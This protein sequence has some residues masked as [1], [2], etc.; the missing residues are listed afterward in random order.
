MEGLIDIS[1]YPAVH[2]VFRFLSVPFTLI[3]ILGLYVI[4][5]CT[6]RRVGSYKNYMLFLQ[7]NAILYDLIFSFLIFPI[8]SFPAGGGYSLGCLSELGISVS[9]QMPL[10]FATVAAFLSALGIAL[11]SRQQTILHHGHRFKYSEEK[12]LRICVLITLHP[13]YLVVPAVLLV[14]YFVDTTKG[15][16]YHYSKYPLLEEFFVQPTYYAVNVEMKYAC[17][18]SINLMLFLTIL[19]FVYLITPTFL[20]LQ[21][22]KKST[23]SQKTLELQQKWLKSL[24]IQTSTFLILFVLPMFWYGIVFFTKNQALAV[25]SIW[26]SI[27][28]S[29]H[30]TVSTVVLFVFYENYRRFFTLLFTFINV[31]GLYVVWT[32]TPRRIGSYKNYMLL[33]QFNGVVYDFVMA[34]L[35]FP[36]C[37]MPAGGG[38]G[39]GLLADFGV[40]MKVHVPIGVLCATCFLVSIGLAFFAR[41]QAVLTDGHPLKF[42][43]TAFL[44][45][46]F[47]FHPFWLIC[48]LAILCMIL[49][50]TERAQRFHYT[51]LTF[52]L[53]FAF[54]MSWFGFLF[55]T[56]NSTWPVYSIWASVMMSIHGTAS[57]IELFIF[58]EPY[59][60]FLSKMLGVWKKNVAEPTSII[61]TATAPNR[62]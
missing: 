44:Q 7:L 53:L 38:Y 6:P 27:I 61:V 29:C 59:R 51:A 34:I 39:F 30:G 62:G 46:L 33:L 18:S 60:R 4:W 16:A 56:K 20:E 23:I 35:I 21:K 37:A 32:A 50:D 13:F 57:T 41:Q 28:I 9:V 15:M 10:G 40:S 5:K 3:N 55:A 31:Y 58:Y 47:G 14:M 2:S 22:L 54:P 45:L 8:F 24:T 36:I 43:N 26:V 17:I 52:I 42:T 48:P 1:H 25:Y 12:A 19:G 49:V 11:F